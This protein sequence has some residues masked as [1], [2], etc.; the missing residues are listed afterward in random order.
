MH[1]IVYA[2]DPTPIKIHNYLSDEHNNM[3]DRTVLQNIYRDTLRK[4]GAFFAKK[5]TMKLKIHEILRSTRDKM[6]L[7][8]KRVKPLKKYNIGKPKSRNVQYLNR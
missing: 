5:I 3:D 4:K 6:K 2:I 8:I 1:V 7:Y